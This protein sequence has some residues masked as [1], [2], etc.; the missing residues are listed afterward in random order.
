MSDSESS[1]D[2]A[3]ALLDRAAVIRRVADL[4]LL[5]F[6]AR[7]P[8]TLL[9]SEALAALLGYEL[10]DIA[11]SLDSLL[12]SGLL[13]RTQT[14]AHPARLYVFAADAAHDWVRPLLTLAAT[15][16]GRLACRQVLA[17][18]ARDSRGLR[19]VPATGNGRGAGEHSV[20]PR[21]PSDGHAEHGSGTKTS[22][23]RSNQN[24]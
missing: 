4:D 3:R 15:R 1:I 14:S 8:R 21:L 7:H 16:P 5:V 10:K 18:R 17:G 20:V 22:R 11:R 19:S 23:C 6:F 13:E 24:R 9:A 2:E 12:A